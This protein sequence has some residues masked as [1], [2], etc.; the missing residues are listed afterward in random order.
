MAGIQSDWSHYTHSQEALEMNVRG[1]LAFSF[2]SSLELL[3]MKRCHPQTG[4]SSINLIQT[5]SHRYTIRVGVHCHLATTE[6]CLGRV[7]ARFSRSGWPTGMPGKSYFI[8]T[9]VQRQIKSRVF[10]LSPRLYKRRESELS[11]IMSAFMSFCPLSTVS[12][13]WLTEVLP[14][15]TSLLRWIVTWNCELKPLPMRER[16]LSS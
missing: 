3:P 11:V 14:A 15:L 9:H 8:L 1:Q 12:V 2:W 7:S 16:W 10:R 4:P 5:V 6:N 13:M